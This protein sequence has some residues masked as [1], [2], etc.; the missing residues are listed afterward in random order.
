MFYLL[1]QY[2]L[3]TSRQ[4]EPGQVKS[5][6]RALAVPEL[7]NE[8]LRYLSPKDVAV[9]ARVCSY[10]RPFTRRILWCNL[11]HPHRL[12]AVYRDVMDPEKRPKETVRNLSMLL[13]LSNVLKTCLYFLFS[14]IDCS[15]SQLLSE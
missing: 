9:C 13:D 12:T 15:I 7:L 5:S 1:A 4:S 14:G 6:Q 3:P 8:V 2:L 10:W 11:E